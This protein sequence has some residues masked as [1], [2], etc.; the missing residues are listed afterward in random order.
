MVRKVIAGQE[1]LRA[2]GTVTGK[3]VTWLAARGY[4]EPRLGRP[5]DR[6]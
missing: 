4:I 3:L 5:R 2:P 1:L 6:P